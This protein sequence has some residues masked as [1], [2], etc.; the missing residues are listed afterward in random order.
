MVV[1]LWRL[2]PDATRTAMVELVLIET[3]AVAPAAPPLSGPFA[4]APA[5]VE[6]QASPLP[7]AK[8]QPVQEPSVVPKPA[9]R[10]RVA[11][12]PRP[13]PNTL[14]VP[15]REA[16]PAEPGMSAASVPE[17]APETTAAVAPPAAAPQASAG[18]DRGYMRALMERLRRYQT[19]PRAARSRRIEG[20][21]VVQLTVTP[22]GQLATVGIAR[23]SGSDLLDDAALEMVRRA[24]PLPPLPASSAGR[25][26]TLAVPIV[27]SLNSAS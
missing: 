3:A 5:V 22:E 6:P 19:Y 12:Q 10:P 24:A 15:P 4:E 20:Q 2:S 9:P 13:H 11:A 21:V 7:I 8:P 26:V 18:E 23:T 16:L 27:F 14:L 1:M 17:P 25:P